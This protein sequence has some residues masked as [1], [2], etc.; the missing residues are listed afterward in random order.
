MNDHRQFRQALGQFPTGVAV[1]TTCEPNGRKV[2]LTINSFSSVSLS[3]KLISWSLDRNSSSFQPF[4]GATHFAVHILAADQVDL[5]NRFCTRGIDRFADVK[6]REGCGGLP[7]LDGCSALFECRTVHQY[8]GGDHII[9]IGE[10]L[11]YTHADRTP[12]AFYGGK[13]SVVI[14]QPEV[15]DSADRNM[16][17]DLMTFLL[18]RA[19]S[20][21][22][23]PLRYPLQRYGFHDVHRT[24]LSILGMGEG[25]SVDELTTLVSLSG[26][27]LLPEH[28]QDLCDEG[29]IELRQ[30]A[31]ETYVYFT[32]AGM[33]LA[34]E[35]TTIGKEAEDDALSVFDQGEVVLLKN[36]LQKLIHKTSEGLPHGFGKEYFWR[37]NNIWH[38]PAPKSTATATR[39]S[40]TSN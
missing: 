24:V 36:L 35:Q 27:K 18:R 22:A 19:Y 3:P 4:T 17:V 11:N 32:S 30:E 14:K 26:H 29:F 34:I 23:M 28:Y 7:L 39:L 38:A 12:L 8:D 21:L 31:G 20:Q 5:A 37:D 9:F 40:P 13:Y 33:A 10:V 25:R 15:V 6:I 1:I 16:G 2:G